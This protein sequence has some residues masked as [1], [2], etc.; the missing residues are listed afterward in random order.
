MNTTMNTGSN[1]SIPPRQLPNEYPKSLRFAEDET[2][3]TDTTSSSATSQQQQQMGS[4]AV[5][6]LKIVV[7]FILILS[8]LMLSFLTYYFISQDESDDFSTQF[9]DFATKV[10]EEFLDSSHLKVYT[11]YSLSIAYTTE[12]E[13]SDAWPAVSLSRFPVKTFGATDLARASSI[14]FAPYVTDQTRHGWETYASTVHPTLDLDSSAIAAISPKSIIPKVE[15][16]DD[17]QTSLKIEDGIYRMDNETAVPDPGP[18]PYFP[19]WQV[20]PATEYAKAIMY[21]QFSDSSRNTALQ[22]M[23]ATSNPIYSRVFYQ[24]VFDETKEDSEFETRAVLY[25]PVFD[26]F[27][28]GEVSGAVSAEFN[29]EDSFRYILPAHAT[30]IVCVLE[31]TCGQTFTYVIQGEDTVFMG[32]GDLH[33]P[34]YDE[35]EI[36]TTYEDFLHTY[37]AAA[38]FNDYSSQE[39]SSS[40][41]S[42]TS[43]STKEATDSERRILDSA[44]GCLY[45]VRIYPSTEF[46]SLYHTTDA[47]F[48]AGIV[49]LVFVFTSIIFISYD[50]LVQRRQNQVMSTA[51]RAN[52]IIDSLFPAMVRDRVFQTN[53]QGSTGRTSPANDWNPPGGGGG[54]VVKGDTPK[55]RLR[56]FLQVNRRSSRKIKE[57]VDPMLDPIADYFPETT[58]M[59]ADIAGFTAWSSERNPGEVFQLLE[60]VY[61]AFDSVARQMGVFK[62]ETIGDCYVA[63]TGLPEPNKDHAIIMTRFA[64]EA[65]QQMQETTRKLEVSL[66][67]GTSDLSIRIGLHSGPVTGGVLRGEKS[68]FQLFGDTMNTAARMES[69]G[70]RDMVQISQATADLLEEAGKS[71]WLTPRDDVVVAKGK[72]EMKTYWIKPRNLQGEEDDQMSMIDEGSVAS[73]ASSARGSSTGQSFRVMFRRPRAARASSRWGSLTL[74]DTVGVKNARLV[75]WNV[76]QLHTLLQKVYSSRRAGQPNANVKLSPAIRAQ[77]HDYVSKIESLYRDIPF[78]NFEHASHVSM[79]VNKLMRRIVDQEGSQADVRTTTFG[80]SEDPLAHFAVVFSALIADVDHRGVPN[81]QLVKERDGLAIRYKN[82]SVAEQNSI[83]LAWEALKEDGYEDLRACIYEEEADRYRFRQ[84]VANAVMAT[85]IKE[86]KLQAVRKKRW[87]SVFRASSNDTEAGEEELEDRKA[88]LVIEHIMQAGNVAHTMQHWTIFLK[89]NECLYLEMYQAFKNGRADEDPSVYWY[90]DELRFFDNHVLP[91]AKKLKECGVFGDSGDEYLTLAEQNRNEWEKK[92]KEICRERLEKA[93]ENER[94][95]DGS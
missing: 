64:F 58:I 57:K 69:T 20:S 51:A 31:N 42:S 27:V 48:Y 35:M 65:L 32:T 70:Q 18:G 6:L 47:M 94:F 29:W 88:K 62:L 38:L 15:T 73:E 39:Y 5:V 49:A 90:E 2:T 53:E 81:E 50:C 43:T 54:G 71:H 95:I 67:P 92:G 8:A 40:S 11:C 68:R 76:D 10:M 87:N 23:M 28:G 25:F 56:S 86:P 30:G 79:S 44:D 22:Q 9:A 4:K 72:G 46:E 37:N 3:T 26:T 24:D 55:K 52:A 93:N 7:I 61:Y 16:G 41:T 36:S 80:L 19:L 85:D 17:S 60:S 89:W 21:N 91:V 33:D 12:F 77:L 78:H 14:G 63:A 34:H 59:F 84:L 45:L 13:D 83:K 1:R 66:G 74:E 82:K 75:D